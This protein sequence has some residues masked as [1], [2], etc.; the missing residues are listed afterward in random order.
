MWDTGIVHVG[1]VNMRDISVVEM[2]DILICVDKLDICYMGHRYCGCGTY[3]LW[4]W[5]I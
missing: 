4:T 1:C 5:G 2:W 3:I